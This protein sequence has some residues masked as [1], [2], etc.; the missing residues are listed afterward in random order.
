MRAWEF[1]S[2]VYDKKDKDYTMDVINLDDIDPNPTDNSKSHFNPLHEIQSVINLYNELE[3]T[4]KNFT[5]PA[6]EIL[7]D[8]EIEYFQE[9]LDFIYS[10]VIFK[11]PNSLVAN[12]LYKEMQKYLFSYTK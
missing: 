1:L 4:T 6:A 2:E 8:R 7:S 11:L 3:A 10:K 5:K 9:Q 12:K